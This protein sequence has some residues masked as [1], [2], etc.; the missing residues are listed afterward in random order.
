MVREKGGY[1]A[2]VDLDPGNWGHRRVVMRY[3]E[4]IFSA[5]IGSTLIDCGPKSVLMPCP[6]SL[7]SS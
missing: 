6:Y 3:I 7:P 5:V 2:W 1:M 4:S